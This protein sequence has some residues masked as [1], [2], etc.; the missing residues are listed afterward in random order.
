MRPTW[1]LWVIERIIKATVDVCLVF[2]DY[3][4]IV[5]ARQGFSI[6]EGALVLEVVETSTTAEDCIKASANAER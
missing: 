1:P 2:S 5:L 6:E 4:S 3:T